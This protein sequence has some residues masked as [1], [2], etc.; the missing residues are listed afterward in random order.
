M[1]CL[2]HYDV[3]KRKN[4]A[5]E[6]VKSS[7]ALKTA[8]WAVFYYFLNTCFSFEKTVSIES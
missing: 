6:K 3:L 2:S 4:R 8:G 1:L 7:N 5:L